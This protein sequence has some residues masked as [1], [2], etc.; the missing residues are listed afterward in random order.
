MKEYDSTFNQFK[1]KEGYEKIKQ[2]DIIDQSTD[3]N[4]LSLPKID[5]NKHLYPYCI[6]WTPLPGLSCLLP[7][8]GHTGFCT[9]TGIIHDFAGSCYVSVNDMAFGS[10]YKYL[11]LYP[12]EKEKQEW[13][14]AVAKG[15]KRFNKQNHNLIT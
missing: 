4:Q 11:Q 15:D 10:P 7:S 8:I 1:A 3:A 13:D 12:N 5:I 2:N 9:S 14:N 6:V